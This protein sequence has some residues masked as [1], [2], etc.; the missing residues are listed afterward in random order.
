M[1][2][3]DIVI[4]RM[5]AR[6]PTFWDR[7]AVFFANLKSLFFGNRAE[8]EALM[9]VVGAID[10][11]GNRLY[12][13]LGLLFSRRT[14]LLVLERPPDPRLCGFFADDLGLP[15][16]DV[17]ILA[18]RDYLALAARDGA[19][20]GPQQA[21]VERLTAHPAEWVDGFVTDHAL[22]HIAG[23]LGKPTINSRRGSAVGNNKLLLHRHLEAL[24]LPV[25]DTHLAYAPEDIG[26]I[27]PALR[28]QGYAGAVVKAQ[29]GASGIG[30]ARMGADRPGPVPDYLFHDGPCLVQ[31]WLDQ[32][33]PDVEP[34]GSPS[35]QFFARTRSL[36]LYDLTEQILDEGSI[37][38]GNIAP[39]PW[40]AA[41]PDAAEPILRQAE[42]VG[43]WLINE[44]YRGTGSVDFH[45][46]RRRGQLEIRV[47][48]V[49]ARVTG[50]T[51]PA[52]LARHLEPEGCWLMRNLR[53]P[54]PVAGEILLRRLRTHGVLYQPDR[55]R[56]VLPIN[57]NL[58]PE[59]RTIK[60]QFLCLDDTH[61]AVW[62][63]LEEA[64][65]AMDVEWD[66]ERD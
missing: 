17:E 19:L 43:R 11:Y 21:W 18:H 28:K 3:T 47:C 38:E 16:P 31:G 60:G 29:V 56:G 51:Y 23:R 49:N 46:V 44:D 6:A 62:E 13:I 59:G 25:F 30:M 34:I 35:V 37:H 27:L 12:P 58:D 5:T 64:A 63:L 20:P 22:G 32:H 1:S 10:T 2:E 9:E 57:F 55:H 52:I 39:P 33:V 65:I 66:F 36:C 61:Q 15:V 42:A 45:V 50:A 7:N 54:T 41:Y 48:E 4:Q 26:A 24:G 14:N 53:F 8:T 40:L